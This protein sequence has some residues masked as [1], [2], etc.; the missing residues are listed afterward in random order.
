M[1]RAGVKHI[2]IDASCWRGPLDFYDAIL[3]ALDAPGWHGHSVD[4]LI[5]SIIVG[6]INGVDPPYRI[7][8]SNLLDAEPVARD[9]LLEAFKCLEEDGA[10]LTLHSGRAVLEV[11]EYR[12]TDW[13][14]DDPA[15][16]R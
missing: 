8:V 3:A 4:A 14:T 15:Q 12:K 11:A 10:K 5:D 13:P 2:E 1:A 9:A 16:S 7:E 6:N